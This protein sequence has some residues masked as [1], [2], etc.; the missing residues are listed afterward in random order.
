MMFG[1]ASENWVRLSDVSISRF[2]ATLK[3]ETF[4]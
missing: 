3:L 2:H 1:R 4:E